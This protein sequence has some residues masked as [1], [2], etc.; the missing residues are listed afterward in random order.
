MLYSM[1]KLITSLAVLQ[2][3]EA[4][5][6]SYDDPATLEKYAPELLG[7]QVLVSFDAE[8]GPVFEERKTPLTLRHLVTHTSG[9]VYWPFDAALQGY[10]ATQRTPVMYAPTVAD[11][12]QPLR[13]QPGA[14]FSYGPGLDWAGVVLERAT[15]N[16]LE[17]LF[18]AR[19]LD[20]L[21][22]SADTTFE[23][24][25][26][27]L[28][29]W[30]ATVQRNP[31]LKRAD[32]LKPTSGPLNQR[33]G[34]DGLWSTLSDY[35]LVCGGVLAASFPGGI[36][37]P[38]S[39]KQLFADALPR[40]MSP[41]ALGAAHRDLAG[42]LSFVGAMDSPQPEDVGHSIA[43]LVT[44]RDAEG[45]RRA[46]S[47]AWIGAARTEFAIDPTAG[48]AWAAMTQIE[49]PVEGPYDAPEP[50]TDFVSEMEATLYK[51]LHLA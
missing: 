3:V 16:N 34:G 26:D 13:F 25:P 43:S 39:Q 11:L 40:V 30:Q 44:R 48:I 1:S 7:Q 9:L 51:C 24:R 42:F 27:I 28:S 18:R 4:G 8:A 14:K 45:K 47:A 23:H 29:R 41:E 49:R 21:H 46:G 50:F 19:I 6:L 37:S 17:E 22:V 36:V 2:Q 32:P 5:V 20:P 12:T 10:L 31:G 33:K 38:A 35:L 15:G